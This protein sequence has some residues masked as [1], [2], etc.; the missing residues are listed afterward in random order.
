MEHNSSV[1]KPID[2][3]TFKEKKQY[4]CDYISGK[5]DGKNPQQNHISDL[6]KLLKD[7]KEIESLIE[8]IKSNFRGEA[9]RIKKSYI[10]DELLRSR[11]LLLKLLEQNESQDENISLKIIKRLS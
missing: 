3:L 7:P 11:L 8:Y 6:V 4:F 9:F 10:L 2:K 5:R 1:E